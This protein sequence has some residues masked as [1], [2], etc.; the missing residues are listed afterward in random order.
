MTQPYPPHK[1]AP[2]FVARWSKLIAEQVQSGILYR[3]LQTAIDSPFQLQPLE[4]DPS[5]TRFG[6][7]NA[8][9]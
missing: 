1:H 5:A 4:S 7:A 9:N 3:R 2:Q 8:K 6:W